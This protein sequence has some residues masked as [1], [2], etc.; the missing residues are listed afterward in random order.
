MNLPWFKR[1]GILF[2][3]VSIIGWLL[4]AAALLY[5]VYCFMD[6]DRRAHSVSDSL[7]NF[8][9]NLVIIGV[10]YSIIAFFSSSEMDAE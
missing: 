2:I 1:K 3:P 6:I 8:V 9:F 7:M 10:V 4:L 5:A